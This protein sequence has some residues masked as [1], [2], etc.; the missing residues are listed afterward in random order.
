MTKKIALAALGVVLMFVAVTPAQSQ[1]VNVNVSVVSVATL[2]GPITLT[3]A[4]PG[5]EFL[6]QTGWSSAF[7]VAR[8]HPTKSG[9]AG[10]TPSP[11]L[12]VE[13]AVA[14]STVPSQAP[15]VM[16]VDGDGVE[17]IVVKNG[18]THEIVRPTLIYC[19]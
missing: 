11:G 3:P 5:D 1:I 17:E 9:L 12:C 8:I 14:S 6:Y 4:T 2:I 10:Q 15:V 13:M 16:D 19:R 7:F 18:S